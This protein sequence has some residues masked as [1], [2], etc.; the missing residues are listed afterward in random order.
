MKALLRL[1]E[2]LAVMLKRVP[3]A[4]EALPRL[5]ELL[6]AMLEEL[7]V[8]AEAPSMLFCACWSYWP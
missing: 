4:V 6:V 2:L 5:L 7:H 3:M 8:V 1:L